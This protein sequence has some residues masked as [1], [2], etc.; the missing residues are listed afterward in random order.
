[1]SAFDADINIEAQDV[2]SGEDEL[3]SAL[4]R[5]ALKD[6][7]LAVEP[8]GIKVP[9]GGIQVDM[10]ITPS[11]TDVKFNIKADIDEFDLGIMF[12]RLKPGTD[13]G[14]KF[15]LD[16]QLHSQAEDLA[17]VMQNADGHFDFALVPENFSAGVIDLWAVNLLSAIMD[18]STEKDE[19]KINC[20]VVR[21]VM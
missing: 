5:V 18:K 6:A 3:G 4:M 10:D 19:S 15:K 20:L 9:G 1:M 13:M 7:R 16:A 17:S 21:L 14:G 11:P 2:R 8:L 12:R